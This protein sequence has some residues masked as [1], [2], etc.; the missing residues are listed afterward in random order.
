[1]VQGT[2]LSVLHTSACAATQAHTYVN[3]YDHLNTSD[4]RAQVKHNYY[5]IFVTSIIIFAI[6]NQMQYDALLQMVSSYC[7]VLIDKL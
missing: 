5:L 1:M 3:E 6:T 4:F 2:C 7:N